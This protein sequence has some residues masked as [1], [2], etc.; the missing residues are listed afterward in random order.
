MEYKKAREKVEVDN[1][2]YSLQNSVG[3]EIIEEEIELLCTDIKALDGGERC[4]SKLED[5]FRLIEISSFYEGILTGAKF[6]KLLY[7][8]KQE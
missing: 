5:V 1:F 4:L 8:E 3:E 6:F 2:L 7:N